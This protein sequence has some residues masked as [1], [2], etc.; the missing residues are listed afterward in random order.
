MTSKIVPAAMIAIALS[1]AAF[2]AGTMT[3]GV[4]KSINVAAQ[5]LTL[6]DGTIYVLP[7]GFDASKFKP[8]EKVVINWQMNKS[9]HVASEVKAAS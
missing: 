8:G 3:T 5:E 4:I 7:K 1:T 2:A 6:Q 9:K